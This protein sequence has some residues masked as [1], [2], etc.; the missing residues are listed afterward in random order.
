MK[1]ALIK[2]CNLATIAA[3]FLLPLQPARAADGPQPPASAGTTDRADI[4]KAISELKALGAEIKTQDDQPVILT[5]WPGGDLHPDLHQ[6]TQQQVKSISRL[7]TL[8]WVGLCYSGLTDASLKQLTTLQNIVALDLSETAITDEG[9][10]TFTSFKNLEA[11]DLMG[12]PISDKG[13]QTLAKCPNLKTLVICFT[14]IDNEALKSVG[15]M[16]SLEN[17]SIG[18]NKAINDDGVTKYLRQTNLKWLRLDGCSIRGQCL[19]TLACRKSLKLLDLSNTLIDDASLECISGYENLVSL[20]LQYDKA[21]TDI[22]LA[23]ISKNPSIQCL[24]LEQ[25]G[26]TEASIDLLLAMPNLKAID[27]SD[28]PFSMQ[29]KKRLQDAGILKLPS[30]KPSMLPEEIFNGNVRG[31]Q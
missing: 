31:G 25:T 22:G 9:C 7:T 17:L 10:E 29:G 14:K 16:K 28:A 2:R 13:V 15:A 23:N 4:A 12:T 26:I 5:F 19:A 24:R 18:N 20:D 30:L 11:L 8:K 27:I 6:L 3:L 1:S 21:V